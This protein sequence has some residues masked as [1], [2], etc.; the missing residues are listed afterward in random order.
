[1]SMVPYIRLE[2]MSKRK[3]GRGNKSVGHT[4]LIIEFSNNDNINN[5]KIINKTKKCNT[6]F[7]KF[8]GTKHTIKSY[9]LKCYKP[10]P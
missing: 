4:Y 5:K 2:Y 6:I 8:A 10:N 7:L 3:I 1:M 9:I